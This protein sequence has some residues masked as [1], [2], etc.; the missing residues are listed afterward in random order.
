METADSIIAVFADH[1][2]AEEAV[3]ADSF[4]VMAHG[5][6]EEMGR[7]KAILDK[8]NPARLDVHTGTKAMEPTDRLAPA[9]I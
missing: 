2:T 5:T 4:L 1:P 9:G 8:L 6:A 7:A 3:K